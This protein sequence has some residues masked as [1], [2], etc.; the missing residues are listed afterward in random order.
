MMTLFM[1][2]Y[3][4]SLAGSVII[5]ILILLR[6][7]LRKTASKYSY[8]L[9]IAPALR[10]VCPVGYTADFSLFTLSRSSET[11]AGGTI[12]TIEFGDWSSQTAQGA[13]NVVRAAD[14]DPVQAFMAVG[15]IIWAVGIIIFL[16][17]S[18]LRYVQLRRKL[19]DA[20][21]MEEGIFQSDRINAPFI[22]GAM[23]PRIYLPAGLD[24]ETRRY[25]LSH[26]REHL[27][28]KDHVV[29]I[30]AY[31]ILI[32]HWFNPLVWLG[33]ALMSRDMEMSCDEAVLASLTNEGQNEEVVRGYGKA[34]LKLAAARTNPMPIRL[35][36]TE[37]LTEKRIGNIL[38]WR[39]P[40]RWLTPMMAVL[41]A[42]FIMGC[43]ANPKPDL[44]DNFIGFYNMPKAEVLKWAGLGEADLVYENNNVERPNGLPYQSEVYRGD[45]FEL[46]LVFYDDQVVCVYQI[47]FLYDKEELHG[48]AEDDYE[49]M[50]D[51]LKERFTATNDEET[52]FSD[53]D[54]IHARL[55]FRP[56]FAPEF[57]DGES[58]CAVFFMMGK[59]P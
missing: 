32:L 44:R 4:M 42:F 29:K 46:G 13:V 12:C 19:A 15:G 48:R 20:V 59:L 49:H 39:K 2:V 22:L 1:Y 5:V 43:M 10:L 35:A 26:E 50:Q 16:A 47:S 31:A 23:H 6:P 58:G 14:T 41:T 30:A 18:V 34:L 37:S 38:G 55:E 8:W 11:M 17:W 27:H 28:R 45:D 21:K 33:F 36:F 53:A 25:V 40:A 52:T 3:N 7:V 57:S 51:I 56:N 9:W 54:G 24:S